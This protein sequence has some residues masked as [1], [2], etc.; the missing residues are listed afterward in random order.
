MS[1][2]VKCGDAVDEH[3]L[4]YV[5]CNGRQLLLFSRSHL[6]SQVRCAEGGS[7]VAVDPPP[8]NL[9]E[10]VRH[11]LDRTEIPDLCVVLVLD[12][13]MTEASCPLFIDRVVAIDSRGIIVEA[14]L[15]A[16][17]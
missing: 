8:G 14:E 6:P 9:V 11:G 1:G 4:G 3:H 16:T 13:F 5:R 15:P 2:F 17:R 7:A 10:A 12:D